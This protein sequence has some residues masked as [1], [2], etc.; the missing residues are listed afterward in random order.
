MAKYRILQRKESFKKKIH[1]L[2]TVFIQTKKT[3][4]N[5][6]DKIKLSENFR[7]KIKSIN[8][9]LGTDIVDLNRELFEIVYKNK[10]V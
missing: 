7:E 4:K 5:Q 8:S 3:K 9:T 1:S 2:K 6:L 10:L